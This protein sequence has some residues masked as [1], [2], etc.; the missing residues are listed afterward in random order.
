MDMSLSSFTRVLAI[1]FCCRP[2]QD[3][4][5]YSSGTPRDGV[6][7][8]ARASTTAIAL[9]LLQE[10][11]SRVVDK[12]LRPLPLYTRSGSS[13]L[14]TRTAQHAPRR[15]EDIVLLTVTHNLPLA[16]PTRASR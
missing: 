16:R 2:L 9:L 7:L 10:Y 15:Q 14:L 8:H 5:P 12:L 3:Y 6:L 13:G 11:P 4:I 1:S